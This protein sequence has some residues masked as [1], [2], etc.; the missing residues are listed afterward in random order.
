M[1]DALRHGWTPEADALVGQ[2]SADYQRTV[3]AIRAFQRECGGQ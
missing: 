2:L 3:D 1:A